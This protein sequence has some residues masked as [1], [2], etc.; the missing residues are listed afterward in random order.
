MSGPEALPGRLSGPH[1]RSWYLR[2][3]ALL[4][5]AAFGLVVASAVVAVLAM[6]AV[7]A[8]VIG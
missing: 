4:A 1:T 7:L 5:A 6:A 3:A 8:W 2:R